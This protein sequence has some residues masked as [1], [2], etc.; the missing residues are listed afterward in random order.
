MQKEV[1]I[2]YF[3]LVLVLVFDVLVAKIVFV[4]V[5]EGLGLEVEKG[6]SYKRSRSRYIR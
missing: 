3:V 2:V 1:P 6:A 4:V 5:R